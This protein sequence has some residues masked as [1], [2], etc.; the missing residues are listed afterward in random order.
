MD[1]N[2]KPTGSEKSTGIYLVLFLDE[3]DFKYQTIF[4]IIC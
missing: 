4:Q 3:E 2:Y 1:I